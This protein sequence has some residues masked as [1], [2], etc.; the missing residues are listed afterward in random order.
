MHIANR[1]SLYLC[2][3]EGTHTSADYS[4]SNPCNLQSQH[5]PCPALKGGV[6][7]AGQGRLPRH[8]LDS[9][10][11][12]NEEAMH[13]VDKTTMPPAWFW[14]HR[15][16]HAG[17]TPHQGDCLRK[18]KLKQHRRAGAMSMPQCP[19]RANWFSNRKRRHRKTQQRCSSA[20][21]A[22][23]G[24]RSSAS[25]QRCPRCPAPGGAS[26]FQQVSGWCHCGVTASY[27]CTRSV[28]QQHN[29]AHVHQD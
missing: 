29:S 4:L 18:A 19:G 6:W 12:R 27:T 17:C 13:C 5:S 9:D 20:I 3:G 10:P 2:T 21:S 26:A 25:P 1:P 15:N 8:R 22:C 28:L 16:R 11:R 23:M 14:A 24:P 7:I